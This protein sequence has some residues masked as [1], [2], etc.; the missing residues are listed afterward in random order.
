MIV[1]VTEHGRPDPGLAGLSADRLRLSD[2]G[3]DDIGVFGKARVED[4]DEAPDGVGQG[5]RREWHDLCSAGIAHRRPGASDVAH[6]GG[7][8]AG[9]TGGHAVGGSLPEEHGQDPDGQLLGAVGGDL[10]EP[11][12]DPWIG[13]AV[14]QCSAVAGHLGNGQVKVRRGFVPPLLEPVEDVSSASASATVTWPRADP[15]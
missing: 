11:V 9:R 2:D 13:E 6:P 10:F 12:P 15:A 4:P 14:E 3:G 5:V 7:E 1:A 8:H